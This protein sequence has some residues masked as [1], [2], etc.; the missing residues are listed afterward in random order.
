MD[1][2]LLCRRSPFLNFD[3]LEF[4]D[5]D[6]LQFDA[7]LT[8][9][10]GTPV[11]KHLQ[12]SAAAVYNEEYLIIVFSGKY[13]QLRIS[14]SEIENSKTENLWAQS[15]VYEVFV[16]SNAKKTK[17]YREFQL[18]PDGLFFDN[19]VNLAEEKSDH[20]WNSGM[21]G[22][23]FISIERKIWRSLFLLP[24]KSINAQAGDENIFLNLYRASGKFHGD[25]LLA[26]SP[27]GFGKKCFHQPEKFGVLQFVE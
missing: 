25:E 7:P 6:T 23:S 3:A 27:T 19:A 21:K 12:T 14:N 18:S 2:V 16:G 8:F 26:W 1:K 17:Q 24:W 20:S 22:I 5:L 4:E 10:D 13:E 15:D 9:A 11:P